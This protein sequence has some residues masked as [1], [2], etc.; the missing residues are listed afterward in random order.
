MAFAVGD[1]ADP[2]QACRDGPLPA[3]PRPELVGWGAFGGEVGDGVNGFHGPF[4][5][6]QPAAF[7]G[8]LDGLTGVWESDAGGHGDGF[9]GGFVSFS[10]VAAVILGVGDR[11]VGPGQRHQLGARG[12][13]VPFHGQQNSARRVRSRGVGMGGLGVQSIGG[14]QYP[15]DVN[16]IE[17]L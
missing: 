3:K 1:V 11:N 9:E 2:L 6:V 17:K 12:R 16:G 14:D 4:L 7:P 5:A 13:L 8:D 15:E 10:S